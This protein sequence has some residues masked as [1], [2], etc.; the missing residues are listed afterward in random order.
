[1]KDS[2]GTPVFDVEIDGE[3]EGHDFYGFVMRAVYDDGTDV[4]EDELDWMSD[5]C[6]SE[7][8]ELAEK[9]RY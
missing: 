7:I 6:Q 5:N 8:Y 9:K 1:M 4:P 2:K 3:W